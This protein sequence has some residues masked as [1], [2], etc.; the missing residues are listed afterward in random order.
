MASI[1]RV[2]IVD[3]HSLFRSGLVRLLAA[4][5]VD[6]VGEA[7]D[8]LEAIETAQELKPD[9]VLMDIRMPHCNGIEATREI[10]HLLPATRVVVLTVSEDDDDL[11]AAIRA[12]ARGYLLKNVAPDDLIRLLEGIA[13]GEAPISG[14]MANRLLVEFAQ[15]A[16]LPGDPA[17]PSV[18]HVLTGR[19]IEVLRC[20]AAGNS[21][22]EVASLLAISENTVKNHLRS[23]LEKLHLANRVQA[24]AYAIRQG[25]VQDS[26]PAGEVVN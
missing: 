3:D 17:N 8:G 2:L 6:V 19:E 1:G 25:L 22:R 13:A 24:V 9:I 5:G 11:F 10:T 4:K 16:K 21:N 14:S 20:V 23:I 18:T 15:R 12:G 26:L 7:A